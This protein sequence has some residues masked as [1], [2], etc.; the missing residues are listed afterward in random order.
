LEEI[1][2][3]IILLF[4]GAMSIGFCLWETGAAKWLAVNWLVMFQKA[5]WFVFVMSISFFVMMM[6]NFIMNVAAIAIS[7][8]VALV[9]APYLGVS[10]E[11]V[12]FASLVV[13]GMPFLLL[14]GAA[15]NAIAY[16]SKQFT[17]GEFFLYG[18]PASVLL[19]VLVGVA[20]FAIWPM[21]G[22]PVVL[23][24]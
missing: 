7:L 10:P 22:M 6:T 16:G 20:A 23:P 21:L 4:G 1:P 17:T 9:I 13:A 15:P 8:P 3:N 12:L 18:I 24:Q 14:V 19:M 11:V 5:N 2:W